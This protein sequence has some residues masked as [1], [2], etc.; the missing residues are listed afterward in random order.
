MIISRGYGGPAM[1]KFHQA[2]VSCR[3]ED[4]TSLAEWQNLEPKGQMLQG[5]Q[6]RMVGA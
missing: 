4:V 2:R 3:E 1:D 5:R 6:Y